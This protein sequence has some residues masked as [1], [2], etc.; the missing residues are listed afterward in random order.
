M[1]RR[2]KSSIAR[3]GSPRRR[4]PPRSG[5]RSRP[6]RR[7][8]R[9]SPR[10]RRQRGPDRRARWTTLARPRPWPSS[11]R[12]IRPGVAALA[13]HRRARSRPPRSKSSSPTRNRPRLETRTTRLS[14]A[15]AGV[16]AAGPAPGV[17][18]RA[19]VG[20]G[21]GVVLRLHLRGDPDAVDR[22]PITGQ[23]LPDREIERAA[24]VA[25]GSPPGTCP[26]RKRW[27]R[28]SRSPDCSERQP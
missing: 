12:A 18:A 1:S 3:R 25:A 11:T 24:V 7:G 26:C 13:A 10:S 28:P 8:P 20:L 2:S 5:A 6:G 16:R 9:A 19:L 22:G 14:A 17:L 23:I 27:S 15:C 4:P 21:L